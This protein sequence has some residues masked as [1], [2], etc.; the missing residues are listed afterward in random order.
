MFKSMT[1]LSSCLCLLCSA[2][3]SDAG[4]VAIKLCIPYRDGL[5]PVPSV[6]GEHYVC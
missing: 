6:G 2:F 5:S 4:A 1:E 3:F